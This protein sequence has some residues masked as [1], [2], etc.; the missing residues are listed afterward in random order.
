M[1]PETLRSMAIFVEVAKAKSFT[2][3]AKALGLPKSTVSRRIVEL[4]RDVGLRLLTRTTHRI[5]L[6]EEGAEYY[7]RCRHV[8][9]EADMALEDLRANRVTVRGHLRVAATADFGMRLVSGLA[10][11]CA[12]YPDLKLDFDFT[13]RRADPLSENFD[14]AIYIGN[15]PDSRLMSRKLGTGRRSL[16]ASPA[17]LRKRGAPANPLE[18]PEHDCIRETRFANQG[19]L[20]RWTLM[21]AEERVDVEIGGALS[22]N[23]IGIVRRLAVEGLGIASIPDDLCHEEVRSGTLAPVLIGWSMPP[24]VIYGLTATRLQPAKTKVFLDFVIRQIS[25]STD[26]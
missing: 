19:E 22:L 17:Y 1:K 24:V 10:E 21:R 9:E 20:Q 8:L 12:T 3:A 26:A 18:L 6:T 7:G 15:P 25:G 2:R 23:S 11:F 4:E 16:Y 13:A 5:E 14:V